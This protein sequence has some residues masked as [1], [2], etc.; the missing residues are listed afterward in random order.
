MIAEIDRKLLALTD[1]AYEA[2]SGAVAWA[3]LGRELLEVFDAATGTIMLGGPAAQTSD[4]LFRGDLPLDAVTAYN[5]HFR[6][7]DLW[8]TRAA[9]AVLSGAPARRQRVWTSGTLVPDEEFLRSEFYA[10][11][12]RPLGLRY[13]VGTV[14]PIDGAR[15]MPIGLHRPQGSRP[16]ERAHLE[17]LAPLVPHLRRSMQVAELMRPKAAVAASGLA[18]LDGLANGVLVV[19]ADLRVLVANAAAEAMA[20]PGGPLRYRRTRSAEA[21]AT[22]VGAVHRSDEA[23]LGALVRASAL[24]GAPGGAIGLR[25]AEGTGV[26]AAVVAPLPGRLI[27]AG[28]AEGRVHGQALVLLRDLRADGKRVD[29]EVLCDVFKLTRAEAEVARELI[30]GATKE[31]VAARRNARETTVRTQVRAILAK[32]GAVNLRDLE[33]IIARLQ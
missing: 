17:M 19:D 24:G 29:T 7:V 9:A 6:K 31:A 21:Q 5:A 16:F 25:D 30:G 26:V 11:F 8:T 3:D 12:G 18:A 2:A 32:T 27:E 33:R 23:A 28:G 13:V 22:V 4:I 1:R 10:D 14:I 20:G 15:L